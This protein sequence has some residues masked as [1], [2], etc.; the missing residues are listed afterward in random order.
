M[1]KMAKQMDKVALVRSMR[2]SQVDHP[3]GIYLNGIPDTS[4]LRMS[5]S[6]RWAPSS[7][8]TRAWKSRPAELREGVV[9]GDAGGGFLGPKYQ[10]FSIGSEGTLPP[11]SVSGLT[12]PGSRSGTDLRSFVE[13]PLRSRNE[14]RGREDAPRGVRGRSPARKGPERIQDRRRVV[15]I[16]RLYGDSEFGKRCLLARRWSSPAWH[17]SRWGRAATTRTPITLAYHRSLV[18]PMEQAWAGLLTDLKDRGCS[19]RPSSCGRERLADPANQQPGWPRSL[20]FAV[21]G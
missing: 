8:S 14:E 11:F 18:P 1:P 2:T 10:S 20:T 15:E 16:P 5:G 3:G 12:R 9:P 21:G 4:R 7:P 19:T 13:R 6:R 17:L